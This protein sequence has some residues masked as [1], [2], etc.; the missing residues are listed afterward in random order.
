MIL[1]PMPI[2]LEARLLGTIM[3][4]S[5]TSIPLLMVNKRGITPD[6]F[7]SPGKHILDYNL[8]LL[9]RQPKVRL[10]FFFFLDRTCISYFYL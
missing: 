5:L 3:R 7:L 9:G 8:E 1:K 10:V 2:T 6:S 4:Q